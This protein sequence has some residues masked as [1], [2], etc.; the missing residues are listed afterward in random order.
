MRTRPGAAWGDDEFLARTDA[1][2]PQFAPGE[3]WAYSNTGY[4]LLRRLLDE[5][6]GLAA[7]LP[8]LGLGATTVAERTEDLAVAV[9]AA[10]ARLRDGVEDVRD[11][12]DQRRI[13]STGRPSRGPP[14][15]SASGETCRPRCAIRA[16][17]SRSEPRRRASSR[18]AQETALGFLAAAVRRR[19]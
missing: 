4:L 11:L 15:S 14:T 1:A 18:P 2:G 10:S 13:R 9:P 19:S 12:Y 17:S 16:R 7:F 3:G 8:R 6:G 5:Y